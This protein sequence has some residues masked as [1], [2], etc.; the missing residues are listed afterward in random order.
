MDLTTKFDQRLQH[1]PEPW[2]AVR[3]D[4]PPRNA[5]GPLPGPT[6]PLLT[7]IED[8]TLTHYCAPGF[9]F[10]GKGFSLT[11]TPPSVKAV[12]EGLFTL[13]SGVTLAGEKRPAFLAALHQAVQEKHI[14]LSD[15]NPVA[16]I[17]WEALVPGA[18]WEALGDTGE[19]TIKVTVEWRVSI[20]PLPEAS[21]ALSLLPS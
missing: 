10:D 7:I 8:L 14:D 17:E 6:S 9:Q 21:D 11:N 20:A 1:V 5:Q 15:P 4:A 19:G 18:E 13:G 2:R 3:R 12:C 16:G